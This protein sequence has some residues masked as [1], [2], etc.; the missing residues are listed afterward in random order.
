MKCRISQQKKLLK[1][2]ME[3]KIVI[4]KLKK[5]IAFSTIGILHCCLITSSAWPSQIK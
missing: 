4:S 1:I 2:L 5:D 3:F